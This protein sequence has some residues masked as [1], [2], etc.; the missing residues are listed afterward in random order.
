MTQSTILV[1]DDEAVIRNII[2]GLLMLQGH[3]LVFAD[4]GNEALVKATEITPDLILLDVMMPDMDGFEVC[5]RLRADP[6]LAEVPIIFITALDDR[7]SR[8]QG[9]KA[10]ADDF[11][12]K[13]FDGVELQARV[14]SI[15]RLNRYRRLLTERNKFEWVVNQ[16][17]DGY[18]M[19]SDSDQ[20]LY[21]NPQA[22]VYLGLLTDDEL[23]IQETFLN[24]VRKQ[25]NLEPEAAWVTWPEPP[26]V[27]SPYYLVRPE[28][29][30]ADSFWLQVD[31]LEMSSKPGEGYLVRMHDISANVMVQKL[32]WTF[33]EQ[34]S[35]KLRTPLA[36]L[37]G[38]LRILREDYDLLS[39]EERANILATAD[40]GG[41][42]LQREI[43]S[44]LKYLDSLDHPP[45]SQS[46]CSVAD[47]ST[48][49]SEITNVFEI[50]SVSIVYESTD[51]P[52]NIRMPISIQTL[53]LALWEI[54]QNA[55]K[56]HP[57]NTPGVEVMISSD[58]THAHIKIAD[59]GLTLS[60]QQ[61]VRMWVPY[62]QVEKGF[63]GQIPGMG[64]GLS[65]VTSLI[66]NVGGAC[67]SYNRENGPG[68]VVELVLPLADKN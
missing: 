18:L 45:P 3:N 15:T 41:Q 11:I 13:P 35:H 49:I 9:I 63:S 12:T 43:L 23:P 16:D 65:K 6:L 7:E 67:R 38:F 2:E 64:L 40:R 37:T 44:V 54:L 60:P 27:E 8:L 5:R 42:Q 19:L 58:F 32:M 31:F 55:K 22:Q 66:W 30:T 1:V 57:D 20:I 17:K 59:D 14:Q 36:K 61:L 47:V 29:S 50:E 10:G 24:R 33:H 53:E 46:Y 62:Y 4:N 56:F 26:A 39:D 34:V 68:I 51:D 48:V 28:S 52:N 25:Y 21:A